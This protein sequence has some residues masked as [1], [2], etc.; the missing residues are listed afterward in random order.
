MQLIAAEPK[1]VDFCGEVL[2]RD[3]AVPR[4]SAARRRDRRAGRADE[5][6][7]RPAAR[8]GPDD[9]GH[10]TAIQ[11][12]TLK[13]QAQKEKNQADMQL[14]GAE[15]QLKDKHEQAKIASQEKI[16]MAKL[17]AQARDEEAKAQGINIKAM[18][19]REKAQMDIVGKQ[20]DM[21]LNE[22][23]AAMAHAGGASQ[24]AGYGHT[25]RRA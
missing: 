3:R 24:A 16:E 13:L 21:R 14:K 6:E 1:T 25:R 23:K 17:M 20:H 5:S 19:E 4:R 22:Q 18:A 2:V 15:L 11:I 7:G 9:C 8:R 12:E 10:K